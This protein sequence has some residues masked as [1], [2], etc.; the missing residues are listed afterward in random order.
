[1]SFFTSTFLLKNRTFGSFLILLFL[2]PTLFLS[3]PKKSAAFFCPPILCLDPVQDVTGVIT[4]GTT[5]VSAGANVTATMLAIGQH[6]KDFILDS[7]AN[8]IAQT[9]IRGLTAQTVN[10]IN[11]GF[12]GNPAYITNPNQF[13]LNAGDSIAGQFLSSSPYT[14]NLCSPYNIKIRLALAKTYLNQ[15]QPTYACTLSKIVQNF[16]NFTNDFSQGGWDA[17]FSV[18]QNTNNNPFGS[19]LTGIDSLNAQIG[20][21]NYNLTKQLDQ[22]KGFLTFNKCAS[23]IDTPKGAAV[24]DSETP[25]TSSCTSDQETAGLCTKSSE[26]DNS[27]NNSYSGEEQG[28]KDP[29]TGKTCAKSEAVTPGSVVES[30]LENVMGSSIRKLELTNSINAVASA[31]MTQL[32]QQVVGGIGSGIRGLSQKSS[33]S[34]TT[35]STASSRTF[36]EQMVATGDTTNPTA[37]D[38]E[39]A[40]RLQEIM[41]TASSSTPTPVDNGIPTK[42]EAREEN[43][44]DQQTLSGEYCAANPLDDI[45]INVPQGA[46]HAINGATNTNQ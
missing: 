22:A 32:V 46:N 17:W 40:T 8:A 14:N 7:L 3:V 11:S 1:M 13:F 6:V 33:A 45:C 31:L 15:T 43:K 34:N 36:L 28:D 35:G 2:V 21:K 4:T 5:G 18:T 12:K 26:V 29:K 39:D 25:V 37:A 27:T 41:R 30:Q 20:N 19:F 9:I 38:K 10:W 44:K 24:G 42:E 16:D 23:W